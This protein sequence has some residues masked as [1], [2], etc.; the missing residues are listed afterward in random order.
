MCLVYS[1]FLPTPS[2]L[3]QLPVHPCGGSNSGWEIGSL[4]WYMQL[5]RKIRQKRN[6]SR[7]RQTQ[8]RGKTKEKGACVGEGGRE[9]ERN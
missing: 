9:R 3:Y 7:L 1:F 6:E 4:E 2:S 8:R 5:K